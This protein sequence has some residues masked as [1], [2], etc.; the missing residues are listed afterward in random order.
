M[1]EFNITPEQK[2]ENYLAYNPDF[3]VYQPA[4]APTPTM[5]IDM[6]EDVEES[7]FMNSL[8]SNN[9]PALF[10]KAP[11]TDTTP[12]SILAPP[13]KSK[14]VSIVDR[15][16]EMK[17]KADENVM[18]YPM[19]NT[20]TSTSFRGLGDKLAKAESDGM[21]GYKAQSTSSSAVGKHQFIWGNE[22]GLPKSKGATAWGKQIMDYTG[23]KSKQEYLN[24]PQAQE[25]WFEHYAKTTLD[26]QMREL[27]KEFPRATINDDD[28]RA[29]IHFRGPGRKDG[30]NG[31]RKMLK[32]SAQMSIKQEQNNMTAKGYLKKI[33][34]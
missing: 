26:P 7:S 17:K 32:D 33:N 20:F 1:E 19:L 31:A 25:K 15:L 12:A 11:P 3:A 34:S 13:A 22:Q 27:R 28:L 10:T 4:Y 18:N 23:L 30:S 9:K 14:A 2:L 8:F 16:N 29:L 6:D 24:N 5:N 21:G